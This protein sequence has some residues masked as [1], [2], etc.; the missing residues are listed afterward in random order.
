[1]TPS[2]GTMGLMACGVQCKVPASPQCFCR[3]CA[4][5]LCIIKPYTLRARGFRNSLRP[6]GRPH[7]FS[8]EFV[9]SRII[10]N[11]G[12]GSVTGET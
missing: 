11:T 2:L 7:Q 10:S 8:W 9:A 1:M 3:G 6:E 4:G 5:I 12:S